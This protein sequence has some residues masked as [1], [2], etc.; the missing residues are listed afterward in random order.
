M[1]IGDRLLECMKS[2]EIG[3]TQLARRIGVS[4][5]TIGKLTRNESR[6]SVHL[7]KIARELGT[8]A[9]YLSGE[10]DDPNQGASAYLDKKSALEDMDLVPVREI[11][12]NFGMGATYM[13]V[14]VTENIRHFPIDFLRSYTRAKPDQLMWAQGLGDSMNP[15]IADQDLLLIDCSQQNLSLADKIWAVAFGEVG[16][17]KRLRPKPDGSI[18][19]LSDN[20]NVPNDQAVDGELHI[21]GRVV[22]IVRKI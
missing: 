14:P 2:R 10:T 13:D 1:T 12:L 17:I 19:I 7:H 20:P 15:T 9:E 21:L 16:M 4:Q 18:E 11:D 5:Q 22:A 8:T 6:S 3:Q